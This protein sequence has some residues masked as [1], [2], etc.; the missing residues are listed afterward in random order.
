MRKKIMSWLACGLVYAGPGTAAEGGQGD[1]RPEATVMAAPAQEW[2]LS[3]TP[4]FWAAGLSGK[5]SGARSPVID[6]HADFGKLFDDLDF[7]AMLIG[8]A[9]KGR[10][11][12]FGDLIYTKIGSQGDTPHGVLATS[13]DVKTSTFAGLL[14]M[15]YSVLEDSPHQL[16]V[17]AGLRVW[18]VDMDV[19]LKGSLLDGRKRSDGAT[20]VDALVGV[21]G[22]Y[23]L[24]QKLYLTGWGLIGAG[25]AE[26]DWDVGLGLGYNLTKTVSAA[27]GYRAVGVDYSKGDFK[28]DAVLQGPMAGITIRF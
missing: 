28:F 27:I 8:D 7:G 16:D 12:I 25:G 5:L 2:K 6:I 17:V 15:G 24:S 4:Y 3:M 11:S 23:I 10:Y 19:T 14:G 20:W 13:A 22:N 18:S 21:R 9:R 1:G 26:A